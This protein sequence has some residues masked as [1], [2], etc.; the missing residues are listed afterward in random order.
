ML[1]I[2]QYIITPTADFTARLD[3]AARNDAQ[4]C[5]TTFNG[6]IGKFVDVDSANVAVKR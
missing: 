5:Y 1:I 6:H 4:L 3:P 2:L